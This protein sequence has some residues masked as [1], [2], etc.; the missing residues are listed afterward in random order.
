MEIFNKLLYID[1]VSH[2]RTKTFYKHLWLRFNREL[3]TL[4]DVQQVKPD[5]SCLLLDS[6]YSYRAGRL[7]DDSL[8]MVRNF[9]QCCLYYTVV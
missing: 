5:L 1:I 7:T 3:P 6:F 2:I 8:L 9:P 4:I